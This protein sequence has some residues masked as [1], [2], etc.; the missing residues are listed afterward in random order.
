M[1]VGFSTPGR[2]TLSPIA[3]VTLAGEIP[4]VPDKLLGRLPRFVGLGFKF[5]PIPPDKFEE[6]SVFNRLRGEPLTDGINVPR[7]SKTSLSRC[8]AV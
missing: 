5:F 1:E 4:L 2:I 6:E 7:F 3:T 8:N